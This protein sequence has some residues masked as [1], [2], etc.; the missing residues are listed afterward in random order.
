MRRL[1]AIVLAGLGA[2]AAAQEVTVGSKRF[3]ESYVLGEIAERVLQDAGFKVS[4]REGM[5]G[6]IILW[7]ALRSGQIAAYPDYSGTIAEEILKRKDRPSLHQLREA[8]RPMG[9]GLTESLGFEDKYAIAVLKEKAGS[10]GIATIG[11]LAKHPNLLPGL[12]P[13]FAER[14]DGWKALSAHYGLNLRAPRTIEHALGYS[15]LLNGQTDL[16]DAY[17]T[18][19]KL[20]DERL[21]LLEDDREF[22]PRYDCVFLYRLD[23]PEKAIAALRTLEGTISREVMVALNAQAEETKD[24]ALAAASYFGKEQERRARQEAEPLVGKIGRWTARHLQIAGLALL[25]AVLIGVPLGMAASRGGAFGGLIL[26][27]AGIVQ[28][29]PSLALLA[30]LVPLPF[31]GIGMQ[32]AVVALFLYSLLPIVRNTATGLRDIPAP[33][34]ESAAA[35]GLEPAAQMRKVFLPMASGAILAGISTSAVISVGTATLAAL[36]G[37]GGLGEPIVSGLNLNDPGTILQGA[38]PAAVLAILVQGLFEGIERAV[39]P[40]GLRRR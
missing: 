10:L 11:D 40:R 7:Q 1:V 38:I 5:G 6:T 2:L 26:G 29:I 12:T 27:F 4:H 3:T 20:L 24:Y 23:A 36:I 16:K 35:M 9:I 21:I 30:L 31:F 39:I 17:T 28:T 25:F 22:F 37:A 34:R 13:E 32:T 18:D 33:V 19:A 8:L 14:Q 15:A